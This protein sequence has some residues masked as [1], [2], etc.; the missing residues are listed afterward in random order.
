MGGTCRGWDLWLGDGEC[1]SR[2]LLDLTRDHPAHPREM[3]IPGAIVRCCSWREARARAWPGG[4]PTQPAAPPDAWTV[5][6]DLPGS[7]DGVTG[8]SD[9]K[10]PTGTPPSPWPSAGSPSWF[11]WGAGEV[12]VTHPDT[13]AACHPQTLL[14]G[15]SIPQTHLLRPLPSPGMGWHVLSLGQSATW[16]SCLSA[17]PL[18]PAPPL[19]S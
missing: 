12:T 11:T 4:P 6:E 17:R 13:Q 7:C 19:R 16:A 9:S 18:H 14:C 2:R 8:R 3:R 15:P 1:R 5:P 10:C